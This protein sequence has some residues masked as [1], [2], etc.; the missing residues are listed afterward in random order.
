M[1]AE[2]WMDRFLMLGKSLQD[3]PHKT[4]GLHFSLG[5][6]STARTTKDD[7]GSFYDHL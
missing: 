3:H 4:G 7:E 1:L 2:K 6:Y 5:I